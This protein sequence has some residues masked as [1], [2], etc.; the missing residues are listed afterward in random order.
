MARWLKHAPDAEGLSEKDF[1]PDKVTDLLVFY[2]RSLPDGAVTPDALTAR[3]IAS[4]KGQLARTDPRVLAAALR[5]ALGYGTAPAPADPPPPP[6]RP[7]AVL[8]SSQPDVEMALRQAGVDVTRI[9]FT[10]FDQAAADAIKYF[11]TYNRTPASQ[12]V[13]DI[14]E[15]IRRSPS[16]VL[17]ADGDA[18]LAAVLASAVVPIRRAILDV[19]QFDN[20]NDLAF[21]DRLYVPGLRRAGDLQTAAAAARG[22][23]ILHDAGATFRLAGPRVEARRLTPAEIAA[24]A[25][26]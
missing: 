24:L 26:K 6:R 1:T 23:L 9:A 7:A 2:S 12:R 4:A 8:A 19:G 22:E 17:V 5:H 11:D 18:G 13:A 10:P 16:A 20:G 15:A 3:W 21:L 25:R 14:V